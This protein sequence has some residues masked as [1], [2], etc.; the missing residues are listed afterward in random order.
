MDIDALQAGPALNDLIAERAMGWERYD[1]K[2]YCWWDRDRRC[3]W[4]TD[5]IEHPHQIGSGAFCPSEY[6]DDAWAVAEKYHMLIA[7]MPDKRL[8]IAGP[9]DGY[10]NPDAGI[11]DGRFLY[12]DMADMRVCGI[13]ATPMLAICYAALKAAARP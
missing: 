9:F 12:N 7:F 5:P 10:F 4:L 11:V 6:I 13:A 1:D 8:W 2:P 3:A